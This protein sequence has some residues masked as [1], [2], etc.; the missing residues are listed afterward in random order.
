[1]GAVFLFFLIL[2]R[3]T[4][5]AYK[6][7][8]KMHK[9]TEIAT[10]S[11]CMKFVLTYAWTAFVLTLACLSKDFFIVIV[12]I[13]LELS[14]YNKVVFFINYTEIMKQLKDRIDKIKE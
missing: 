6:A 14:Y 5:D 1:M 2:T 12:A 3:N 4:I 11:N 8:Y 10:F 7:L 13:V 9:V